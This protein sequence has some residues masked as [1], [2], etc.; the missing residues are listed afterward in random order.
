MNTLYWVTEGKIGNLC[1]LAVEHSICF[2]QIHGKATVLLFKQEHH[3]S[4][5]QNKPQIAINRNNN[6]FV[7]K[8]MKWKAF[9]YELWNDKYIPENYGLKGLNFSA[10]L[11]EMENFEN[12]STNLLKTIKFCATKISFQQQLMGDIGT[13]KNI[14]ETL[15]LADKISTFIRFSRNNAMMTSCNCN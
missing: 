9:F 10:K 14:K 13:I 4:I 11:R 5:I 7:I 6:E 1:S 12:D 8:W 3:L 2:Q 15:T